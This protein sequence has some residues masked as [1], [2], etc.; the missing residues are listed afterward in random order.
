M[1]VEIHYFSYEDGRHHA[2]I[3]PF[4]LLQYYRSKETKGYIA[5]DAIEIKKSGGNRRRTS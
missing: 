1:E 2:R 4:E 3:I 5:I